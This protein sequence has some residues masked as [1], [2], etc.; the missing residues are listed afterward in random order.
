MSIPEAALNVR[1]NEA[2]A[3][4]T[5]CNPKR[6]NALT[7]EMWQSLPTILEEFDSDS[8]VRAIRLEGEGQAAFASGSDISQFG[9]RRSTPKGMALYNETVNRA[10][11]ALSRVSKPTVA[12]VRGF[13]FG[14]GLALAT[15][16]DIR[17]ATEGAIFAVPAAK[18]GIGYNPLWGHKLATLMGPAIAKEMLF[19]AERFDAQRALS[20]GLINRLLDDEKIDV[21][22]NNM[23]KLAPLTQIAAKMAIDHADRTKETGP[24]LVKQAFDRCFA[25]ADYVEGR[26]AFSEKRPPVF[27]GR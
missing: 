15:H 7:F 13:C 24:D 9:E 10:V 26:S 11:A 3:C 4:I 25:S 8:S 14:G 19:S 22:I 6:L 5:I 2:V 21:A 27:M 20:V 16:C 23:V 12:V 18:L 1:I 17:Y